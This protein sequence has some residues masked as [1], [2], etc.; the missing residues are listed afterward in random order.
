[1]DVFMEQ[2]RDLSV[3]EQQQA[4]ANLGAAATPRTG[5]QP[6]PASSSNQQHNGSS[7]SLFRRKF[8][9]FSGKTPVPSAEVDY[10][11]WRM[12]VRQGQDEEGSPDRILKQLVLQSLLRPALE[13]VR[14]ITGT[15]KDVL[16]MLDTLYGSV[17][18]G[19]ELLIQLFNTYQEKE[20]ASAYLQ[21]LF[22]LLM[23]VVDKQ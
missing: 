3:E 15:T 17:A 6:A 18:D 10:T 9:L 4:L 8:R 14:N 7:S 16:Q 12:Q 22:L 21:R 13:T 1:M 2:F 20:T 11:T 19:Q 5:A 23:D